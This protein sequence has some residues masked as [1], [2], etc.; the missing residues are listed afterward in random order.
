MKTKESDHKQ[1]MKMAIKLA[2]KS[3]EKGGGPFGAVIVRDGVVIAKGNNL[4]TLNNDPTAHG[5]VTAIRKACKKLGTFDLSG[6]II[7]TSCEPCPM[8]L[9]A[10]YWARIEAIYYGCTKDDAKDIGF[11][12]SFIYQQIALNPTERAISAKQILHTEALNAFRMWNDKED[13][14]D[15]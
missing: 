3:V 10:I 12:D 1:F 14:V 8:C 4:V 13:R 7:Y 9:S 11:D 6:C 5:E 15:Y 2:E